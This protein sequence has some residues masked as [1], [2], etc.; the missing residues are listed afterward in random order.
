MAVNHWIGRII[1]NI[2]MKSKSRVWSND[3][4]S[5]DYTRGEKKK[6]LI[7]FHFWCRLKFKWVF[8]DGCTSFT[9]SNEGNNRWLGLHLHTGDF[10]CAKFSFPVKTTVLMGSFAY[11]G[12]FAWKFP[13]GIAADD[14]DPSNPFKELAVGRRRIVEPRQPGNGRFQQE[15]G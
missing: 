1:W 5:R 6:I 10:R 7:D 12:S 15:T 2:E 11:H 4:E 3:D 8:M 9:Y 14:N 13:S